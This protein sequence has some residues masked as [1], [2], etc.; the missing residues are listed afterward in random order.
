MRW[1]T[2]LLL[3]SAGAAGAEP[4]QSALSA[5]VGVEDLSGHPVEAVR[6]DTP[7]RLRVRLE[8]LAGPDAPAGLFLSGWLRPISARNLDCAEAARAYLATNRIPTSAIDLNG[9]VVAVLGEGHSLTLVDPDLNLA[10]ANLIGAA[11]LGSAPSVLV[12]DADAGRFLLALPEDGRIAAMPA[13]GGEVQTV[14]EGLDRPVV[15]YPAGGGR[16]WVQEAGHLRLLGGAP[17]TVAATSSHA[18]AAGR[19]LAAWGAGRV[20]V[21][22]DAGATA[23]DLPAPEGLRDA[24]PIAEAEELSAVVLLTAGRLSVHYADA[25]DQPVAIA[26]TGTPDRLSADATGRWVLA[27]SAAGGAVEIVD[28]ALGHVA[29]TV[30][31]SAAVSEIRFSEGAALLMMADHSMVG[32]IDLSSVRRGA[33]ARIREIPLGGAS[34]AR[35][36]EA[37]L[38]PLPGQAEV[39]AI[40]PDTFTGFFIHD[41]TALGDTP[42][43][44]AIRLRGGIPLAA[45]AL[46]RGFREVATGVFETVVQVPDETGYELVA[47]TGI[48][49]LSFCFPLPGAG[50]AQAEAGVGRIALV[51]ADDRGFR[52][53]FSAADGTPARIEGMVTFS[54]LMTGWRRSV[55]FGTDADGRS[56]QAY[57]LPDLGPISITVEAVEGQQFRPTVA[58][59]EP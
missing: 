47:T 24:V 48:G 20:Q 57:V 50:Q 13:F 2:A 53:S 5:V 12:A 30:G 19:H 33:H 56:L 8:N 51:P 35:D 21:L 34:A 3:V 16:L 27:W 58:G 15:V 41:S 6:P 39:M 49:N 55:V 46:D 14:A 18:D 32:V 25:P 43:M 59:A 38:L 31:A 44:S 22:D 45:A 17:L 52:L 1:L 11:V 26:L 29:Q 4:L 54:A 40:H 7:F 10:S 9:A 42:P 28:L 36:G 23:L 37:L